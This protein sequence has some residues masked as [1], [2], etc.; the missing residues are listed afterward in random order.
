MTMRKRGSLAAC[1]LVLL[2]AIPA[3]AAPPAESQAPAP[4]V[5]RLDGI[6]DRFFPNREEHYREYCTVEGMLSW[7]GDPA[8][9]GAV[10][11]VAITQY[12]ASI[13]P[14]G[15]VHKA[16]P[17]RVI[18]RA[19]LFFSPQ[20]AIQHHERDTRGDG[21]DSTRGEYAE[22]NTVLSAAAGQTP[23]RY[24]RSRDA[25]GRPLRLDLFFGDAFVRTEEHYSFAEDG[26]VLSKRN[27]LGQLTVIHY[28]ERGNPVSERSSAEKN[29]ENPYLLYTATYDEQNR[30]TGYTT[31]DANG[32]AIRREESRRIYDAA[33]RCIQ[34]YTVST[35][36][37]RQTLLDEFFFYDASGELI[38]HRLF[39][40]RDARS[41]R[42]TRSTGGAV[43]N[44]TRSIQDHGSQ[45]V[46]ETLSFS[47]DSQGNWTRCV[48][49]SPTRPAIIE[50]TLTYY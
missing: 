5:Y 25:A 46:R 8:L 26:R 18:F 30:L 45:P 35:A 43:T 41:V 36:P 9:R 27:S 42:Y 2:A 38:E 12:Q 24:Q 3:F 28:D 14:H 6:S 49:S 15:K 47:N 32:T 22:D 11:S 4:A 33:G 44:I 23:Y 20:G 21:S 37:K 48:F 1:F 34:R 40:K 19:Q 16:V 7:K 39:Y 13:D 29:P 17:E 50:R 10:K 31:T